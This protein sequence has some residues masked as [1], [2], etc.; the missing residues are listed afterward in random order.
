MKDTIMWYGTSPR[1]VPDVLMDIP[2]PIYSYMQSEEYGILD[3]TSYYAFKWLPAKRFGAPNISMQH[4]QH[5]KSF[6]LWPILGPNIISIQ[7]GVWHIVSIFNQH[8]MSINNVVRTS[9]WGVPDVL[10]DIP[11]P[12]TSYYTLR[13]L[14]AKRF[15][16]SNILLVANIKAIQ[17]SLQYKSKHGI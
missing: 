5:A 1:Y 9:L 17:V 8:L 13:W 10:M 6:H 16:T 15:S 2:R 12:L 14:P 11:R 7:F 3:L 4:V